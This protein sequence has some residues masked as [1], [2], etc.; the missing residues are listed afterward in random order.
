MGAALLALSE[1]PAGAGHARTIEE[2]RGLME[3]AVPARPS[4]PLSPP[5]KSEPPSCLPLL[6]F[7]CSPPPIPCVKFL[8]HR[9]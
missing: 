1:A 8:W 9:L 2:L 6:P 3:G 4:A 7:G 5:K